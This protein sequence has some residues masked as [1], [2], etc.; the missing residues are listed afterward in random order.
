MRDHVGVSHCDKVLAM[1]LAARCRLPEP[2]PRPRL[3][4]T[5]GTRQQGSTGTPADGKG[6]AMRMLSMQIAVDLRAAMSARAVPSD[7]V[8]PASWPVWL[9]LQAADEQAVQ[10]HLP[11]RLA[12]TTWVCVAPPR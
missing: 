3:M 11:S 5:L 8:A 1:H 12:R 2:E 7:G 4:Q 6:C 9:S 10:D